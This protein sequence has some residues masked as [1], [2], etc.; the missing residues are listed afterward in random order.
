MGSDGGLSQTWG[1]GNSDTPEPNFQA[2]IALDPRMP[3]W[4]TQAAMQSLQSAQVP[5]VMPPEALSIFFLALFQITS[6]IPIVRWVFPH[7][8]LKF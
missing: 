4:F 8:I 5:L 3:T 6:R 2:M 1:G 7:G